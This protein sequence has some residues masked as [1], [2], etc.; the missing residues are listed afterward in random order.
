MLKYE[1][2]LAN[3][4]VVHRWY[5]FLNLN[6]YHPFILLDLTEKQKLYSPFHGT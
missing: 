2:P 4:A 6:S 1:V 3:N 5:P